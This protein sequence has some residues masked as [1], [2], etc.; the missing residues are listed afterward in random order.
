[1]NIVL[2]E[3]YQC[4]LCLE[5]LASPVQLPCCQ[6]HLCLGCFDRSIAI[7][8]T[9]CAF[10]RNRIIGFARRK[11]NKIDEALSREIQEKIQG[12]HE[13]TFEEEKIAPID[14]IPAK[15]GELQAYY[16]ECKQKRDMALQAQEN[17]ALEKTLA[18][19]ENDPEYNSST[20]S[21]EIQQDTPKLYSIFSSPTPKKQLQRPRF[22]QKKS[23]AKPKPSHFSLKLW[24]CSSCTYL[25]KTNLKT[26]NMSVILSCISP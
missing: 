10:C 18:F 20:K 2:P 26:C 6:K 11:S 16:E 13:F 12:F 9:T 1:M 23:R 5:L 15:P 25:N 4:P 17:E 19:L 7:T 8:S 22:T 24:T 21:F 14:N 3:R